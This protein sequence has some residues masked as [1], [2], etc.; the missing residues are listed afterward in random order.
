MIDVVRE[1]RSGGPGVARLVSSRS[2]AWGEFLVEAGFGY[3]APGTE[4]GQE[5]PAVLFKGVP[6]WFWRLD[7][8]GGDGDVELFGLVGVPDGAQLR[9]GGRE[10]GCECQV[11]GGFGV[12]VGE[13]GDGDQEAGFGVGTGGLPTDDGAASVVL[14][15]Q[16]DLVADLVRSLLGDF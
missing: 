16:A 7:D 3:A 1:V 5:S 2:G 10:L 14:A 9:F 13:A 4:R 11:G 8:P 15:G 6:G 12:G